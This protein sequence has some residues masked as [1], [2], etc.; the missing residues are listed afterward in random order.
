MT[1]IFDDT[2]L[3]VDFAGEVRSAGQHVELYREGKVVARIGV[4]FQAVPVKPR[5]LESAR[6]TPVPQCERNITLEL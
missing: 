3:E 5:I 6:G 2:S 1:I 4:K